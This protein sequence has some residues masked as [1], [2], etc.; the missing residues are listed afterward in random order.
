MSKK[1]SFMN[2]ENILTEGFFDFIRNILAIYGAKK[3]WDKRKKAN[4]EKK[5]RKDRSLKNSINTF[6]EDSTN[7]TLEC[8]IKLK[9]NNQINRKYL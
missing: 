7:I 4:Y 6:N 5:M 1:N 3:L 2:K 8:T 9:E